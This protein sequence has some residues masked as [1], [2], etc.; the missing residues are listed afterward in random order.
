[1]TLSLN[2]LAVEAIVLNREMSE[3]DHKLSF[4]SL[5]LWKTGAFLAESAELSLS[6]A[7]I[8]YC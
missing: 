1:M 3:G 7:V 5:V 8:I 4:C 6:N 2:G